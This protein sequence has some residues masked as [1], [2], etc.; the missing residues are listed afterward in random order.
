MNIAFCYFSWLFYKQYFHSLRILYYVHRTHSSPSLHSTPLFL[1]SLI[2]VSYTFLV[3][4]PI[5]VVKLVLVVAPVLACNWPTI[6]LIIKGKSFN[7][8]QELAIF[9]SSSTSGWISIPPF[10]AGNFCMTWY[11]C[12]EISQLLWIHFATAF[13]ICKTLFPWCYPLSLALRISRL[14]HEYPW[15]FGEEVW[16]AC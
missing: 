15:T 1:L 6:Y 3:L 9:S 2:I 4:R 8:S 11:A 14:F 10:F 12:M 16:Y 5:C 7:L 13:C